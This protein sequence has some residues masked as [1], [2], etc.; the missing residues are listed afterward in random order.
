MVIYLSKQKDVPAPAE[1]THSAATVLDH[2]AEWVGRDVDEV[3]LCGED[4]FSDCSVVVNVSSPAVSQ[5]GASTTNGYSLVSPN[6]S[7]FSA[8]W[9]Q[10]ASP[11]KVKIADDQDD[12][13]DNGAEDDYEGCDEYDEQ[14]DYDQDCEEL[15]H[16]ISRISVAEQAGGLPEHKGRHVRFNYNSKDEIEEEEG[17]ILISIAHLVRSV[18]IPKHRQGLESQIVSNVS[19]LLTFVCSFFPCSRA[20]ERSANSERKA[21]EISRSI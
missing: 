15:C 21:S 11:L 16:G 20:S 9:Q 12:H 2:S 14:E 3:T 8:R 4:D 10:R 5:L 1:A 6:P 18:Q 7:A 17:N 19:I 13:Y